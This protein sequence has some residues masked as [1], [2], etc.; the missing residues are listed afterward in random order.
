M[1]FEITE[2]V[3]VNNFGRVR[4][5]IKNFKQFGCQFGL[6]DFGSGTSSFSH[7]K[8]DGSLVRNIVGDAADFAMVEAINRSGCPISASTM[9]R[10]MSSTVL[11]PC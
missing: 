8:I 7:L 11:S 4:E 2:T 10:V 1:C 6:D 5:V 3:A 9:P